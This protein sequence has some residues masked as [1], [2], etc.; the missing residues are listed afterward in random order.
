MLWKASTRQRNTTLDTAWTKSSCTSHV[1]DFTRWQLTREED[2][3]LCYRGNCFHSMISFIARGGDESVVCDDASHSRLDL[4]DIAWSF[5]VFGV[6]PQRLVEVIYLGLF[7]SGKEQ[8][9]EHMCQVHSDTGF[10]P[11]DARRILQIQG[12]MDLD[13]SL[14]PPDF[15][16]G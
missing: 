5:A 6:Y 15:A 9:P 14:L 13:G 11:D 10:E 2:D 1:D 3:E 7:G 8:D 4:V 12:A 16:D